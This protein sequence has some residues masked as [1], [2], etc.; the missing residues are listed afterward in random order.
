MRFLF[1]LSIDM[2]KNGPSVHLLNDIM[3]EVRKRGHSIT[4][5]QKK[6]QEDTGAITK[7]KDEDVIYLCECKEPHSLN[8]FKRYIAEIKYVIK[9]MKTLRNEKF[10]AVFLQSC[11]NAGYQ[12]WWINHFLKCPIIYNVQ[13]IFPLDIAYEGVISKKNPVYIVLSM[14]QKYAYKSSARVITI[15]E[16]MKNTLINIGV[17]KEKID[18]VYNWAY[19]EEKNP[20]YNDEIVS[21]FFN[22]SK[23]NVVYAG[24][25]G[26]AQGVENL[27]HACSYLENESDISVTVIGTGSREKKCKEIAKEKKL[28]NVHFYGLV[29]QYL[30]QYVYDNADVNIVTLASGI[31]NTSFPSKTAACYKSKK[32]VV[33]C[34]EDSSI[35]IKKLVDA[36]DMIFQCAPG[37][38]KLL[39]NTILKVKN[40]NKK[41]TKY[42]T[43]DKVLFPQEAKAYVNILESE[44]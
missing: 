21:T 37:D 43:Y 24:N 1:I 29:P 42:L 4:R 17:S 35:T 19:S 18:V 26:T 22:N 33:Y 6:Y 41:Y 8:Y 12:T 23:Y 31:I 27:I 5:M 32:P 28:S 34:V 16:D 15:S 10:D 13:D 25:I 20:E 7:H 3:S 30:A 2:D 44:N 9:C 36:N 40:G 39:A 14:L 11:N 38:P